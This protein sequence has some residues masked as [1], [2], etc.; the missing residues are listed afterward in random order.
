MEET[1]WIKDERGRFRGRR[2]GCKMEKG[3]VTK[4]SEQT[5]SLSL[6]KAP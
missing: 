6:K 5:P 2:P 3:G 1:C 4:I